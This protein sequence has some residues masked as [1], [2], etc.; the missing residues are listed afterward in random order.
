MMELKRT[1]LFNN[2]EQMAQTGSLLVVGGPGTGKSWLLQQFAALHD[3]AG[4]DV[5]LLLAE[6]HNYVES[7]GQLG[8]SLKIPSGIIPTLKAYKGVRKFL[9]IDSLDA[10]RAEASQRVF[11]QLIRQVHRELPE[12][13][14]I[15]SIRSF[16]AME[17]VE[18]QKLFANKPDDPATSGLI[19]RHISVP[20]FS[21]VDLNEAVQQDTRLVPIL[22][23]ASVELLEIL[24]NAF[25]LWL[26]IHLLNEKIGIDWLPEIESEVQLFE[27]Y[28][29]YRI[30]AREDSYDRIRILTDVTNEMV[31]SRT[32]SVALQDSYRMTGASSSFKSLLSDEVLRKTKTERVAYSHNILFDFSVAKLLLDEHR[33]FAFLQDSRKSIFFRPSLS[34]F[35]S[36]LWYKDRELFWSVTSRFFTKDSKLPAR[37]TVIPGIT[38]FRAATEKHDFIPLWKL[39]GEVGLNAIL[40]L[41]RAIQ[42]F[43]G[44]TSRRGSLWLA[45][46]CDLSDRLEITFLNEYLALVE[47]ASRTSGWTV[48]ER[49]Q[50]ASTSI[51]LLNW[52]WGEAESRRSKDSTDQILDIAAGRVI[53]LVASFYAVDPGGVRG[54]LRQVLQRIGKRTASPSETYS[55]ANKLEIII[56]NDPDFAVEV[57]AAAF[58][59]KEESRE[60]TNISRSKIL[61]L[62]STRAQDYSMAY[63][64]LG[65]R[66]SY[67]LKRD[68]LR[69]TLA[70]IRSVSA[71][72]EREHGGTA[73]QIGK[74]SSKFDFA[75][76]QSRLIADRSEIWDQGY[77]DNVSL[78]MLDALLNHLTV[79]LK[80]NALK[81]EEVWTVFQLIAEENK[82]PVVWKRVLEQSSD[83][84]E[85]QP[86]V[87]P[88]LESPEILIAP[89]TT[90]VAGTLV[91]RLFDS[92]GDSTKR[93]IE[94]AIWST[95]NTTIAK[96]Y[97]DRH[98]ERDRILACIP[99]HGRSQRAQTAIHAATSKQA[100]RDNRPHFTVGPMDIGL[101]STE[102]WLRHQGID[103][104][105]EPNRDLLAAKVPLAAFETKY[106]NGVP[107]QEA[108]DDVLIPL[109]IAYAKVKDSKG[110]DQQVIVDVFT[111]VAGVAESILKNRELSSLSKAVTL[112][113]AIAADAAIF[114]HPEVSEKADEHF[115]R[116]MWSPT[117]KIEAAQALI[118]C[119]DNW[120]VDAQL[121]SL[122]ETLSTEKS[123]AVRYQIAIGLG[124]VYNHDASLFWEIVMP[125]LSAEKATGVLVALVRTIGHPFIAKR[126]PQKIVACFKNVLHRRL[127]KQRPEDVFEVLVDSLTQLYVYL[128][129]HSADKVLQS[130]EKSPLRYAKRL[131]LM[132]SSASA[133]L[134]YQIE[135]SDATS[136]AIR[137]RAREV[138]SRVIAAVDRGFQVLEERSKTNVR[139]TP[140]G[141][142]S[143]KHLLMTLDTLVLKLKLLVN[144][145]PELTPLDR[146]PTSD[147][148]VGTFFR[149]S[150]DL[151]NAIVSADS[152]YRHP[153]GPSTA[154][155]LMESFN[156][157]FS[158][159]PAHVLKLAA[160]L[161]SGR[162]FGYEFDSF[163]IREFVKF[164]EKLLADYKDLLRESTNALYFAEI[165]DVFVN[166]GWPD[167][168]QIVTRL[169]A[170]IR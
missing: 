68:L 120:G 61:V 138:E 134:T 48:D 96:I 2:L 23:S 131:Q 71:E 161:I 97:R 162:T 89:E 164:S 57:Y 79:S 72:V 125:M 60:E 139:A 142:E 34:Y 25:N 42:A 22:S 114:P 46:L 168:T 30:S 145:D 32:L 75:G 143:F 156:K 80:S 37:V 52:M 160:R 47:I 94:D 15:A 110:A 63:F 147:S 154:H 31:N 49:K 76:I 127:P 7:L 77:R 43:A 107:A 53:P 4:D 102:D 99:E 33:L 59:Y 16:D 6:E 144:A 35:L 73:R 115:D 109:E 155:N 167:A 91:T 132:A 133:Y 84:P 21:D 163:A 153:I 148:A 45:L 26:V 129:E 105:T 136:S 82:F 88:L 106:V 18:V 151:W 169:D 137:S 51:R 121:Q 117:P 93:K 111:T 81:Q 38:I 1:E 39:T 90:V 58:A 55:V 11:R 83:N 112:S 152:E 170:A 166:A 27:R 29:H 150:V 78:Q 130:F 87:L 41:L 119:V 67:F 108:I 116:P 101:T 5:L 86:F 3:K 123:P 44:M 13:T 92:F 24:R 149:E 113:R 54:V 103:T 126:E 65:V 140:K 50:L 165:L 69:A 56:E 8:E 159:D 36:L 98:G 95:P 12:W 104:N 40:S 122:I 146:K 10:L 135:T 64:I 85:L 128:D 158:Y 20:V 157:L 66:F 19:A 74:Y 28:W 141:R 118:H 100:L 14:V 70:A 124:A 62:T 9:I 17:S